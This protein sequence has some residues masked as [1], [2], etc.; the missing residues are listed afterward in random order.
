MFT[1]P[2]PISS[3]NEQIYERFHIIVRDNLLNCTCGRSCLNLCTY[4]K[5]VSLLG[6][7]KIPQTV[8]IS[9]N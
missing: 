5:I 6:D 7:R 2:L 4:S 3:V 8:R 9:S 1:A